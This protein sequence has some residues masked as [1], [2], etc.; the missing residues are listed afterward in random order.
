MLY[1]KARPQRIEDLYGNEGIK[2]FLYSLGE[3]TAPSFV[4][5][6]GGSGLG[7]TTIARLIARK[8]HYPDAQGRDIDPTAPEGVDRIFDYIEF[9][10]AEQSGVKDMRDLKERISLSTMSGKHRIVYIDEAH[11]LSKQ[12]FD[13]L[14]K[15]TEEPLRNLFIMVTTEPDK[16]PKTIQTRAV[17]VEVEAPRTEDLIACLHNCALEEGYGVHMDVLKRIAYQHNDSFRDALTALEKVLAVHQK[18]EDVTVDSLRERGVEIIP[19][20]TVDFMKTFMSHYY[21]REWG[22]ILLNL[23]QTSE[24][25]ADAT[26]TLRYMYNAI[27]SGVKKRLTNNRNND[28]RADC[29]MLIDIDDALRQP[30][31][32]IN[33]KAIEKIIYNRIVESK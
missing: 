19:E 18:H 16:I 5:L 29:R 32:L 12:A 27:R 15:I 1:N 21:R 10:G 13:A 6:H 30:D 31:Y 2:S 33:R 8:L 26:N 14:L 9:S 20:E 23:Y 22:D 28:V 4:I 25:N 3:A 11:G 17:K 7:K 24:R